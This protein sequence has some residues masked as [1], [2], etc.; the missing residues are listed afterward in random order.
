MLK[1]QFVIQFGAQFGTKILV[2]IAGLVVAR[3][4]GPEVVG[5]IVYGTAFISIWAFITGLFGIGH[6][7]LISEGKPISECLTTYS[8]L[9]GGSI[10][11]YSLCVFGAFLMQKYFWGGFPSSIHETVIIILFITALF[12]EF[13]LLGNVTFM[14]KLEQVKAN[15]PLVIKSIVYNALRIIIV[16]LGLRAIGLATVHLIGAA[17]AIP[18]AWR[19]IKQLKFGKFDKTLLK[20]HI[21]Y[22]IPNFL[23][24]LINKITEYSDKLLLEHFNDTTE[25]G[26]YSAA[27]SIGGMF[28]LISH[29]VGYIFFPLFSGMIAEKNWD[30]VNQ[31]IKSFQRFIT[32]FI[33]PMVCLLAIIGG[34]LL[35]TLIG[36]KYEPSVLPFKIIIFATYL[37]LIGMPYG[38]IIEGMGRFYL[39]SF[40]NFLCLIV[41]VISIYFLTSPNFLGLGAVG[42]AINL[43]VFK[44]ARNVLYMIFSHRIGELKLSL[45][46]I[47]PYLII[48]GITYL[49]I[50]NEAYFNS[51]T[52]LWWLLI[53]PIY[54][55]AIYAVLYLLGFLTN[56]DIN[57]FLDIINIKKLIA[58]IGI[59]LKNKDKD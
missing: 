20:S 46:N 41:F 35:I 27:F 5:T 25:L 51:W 39:N 1:Q 11:I 28:L 3:V 6:I 47:L 36:S 38:N 7:K 9:Q 12:N 59:E 2:M 58:Y 13:L 40:I 33:F 18:L 23:F 17:I 31:K 30:A 43:I 45:T 54:L 21:Q 16:L 55:L 42:V 8:V 26:Y 14:A 10:I 50:Y 22:A 37:S 34:P 48:A 57:Q 15:Y 52:A 29:S 24:V 53:S 49:F 56:K 19:L 4:A 44:F 32:L